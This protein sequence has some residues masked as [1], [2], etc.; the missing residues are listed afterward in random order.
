[1]T[2]RKVPARL[3]AEIARVTSR[4]Q[5]I[6]AEARADDDL[7][8]FAPTLTEVSPCAAKRPPRWPGTAPYDALLEDYEPGDRAGSAAM[9]DAMRPGWWRCATA[10]LGASAQPRA[11]R[12][13]STKPRRCQAVHRDGRGLRL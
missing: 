13:C 10:I 12:A 1:M 6:W 11:G 7:A 8:A 2:A 4:A 3:A 9:F 5:G